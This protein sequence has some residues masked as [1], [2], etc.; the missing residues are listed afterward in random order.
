[1]DGELAGDKL[2]F[3]S[4]I[5]D[6]FHKSGNPIFRQQNKFGK[7]MLIVAEFAFKVEFETAPLRDV[8][9]LLPFHPSI[10]PF[11]RPLFYFRHNYV[12]KNIQIHKKHT[13][14]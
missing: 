9:I 4:Y 8:I 11:V 6:A 7:D 14:I 3:T 5:L 12:H 13:N 1:L 10:H 2:L